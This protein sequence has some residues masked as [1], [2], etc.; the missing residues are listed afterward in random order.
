ML[1]H[2]LIEYAARAEAD[3]ELPPSYYRPKRIQWILQLNADGTEADFVSLREKPLETTAPY[4]YRS[5]TMPPPYL[6]VDTAQY[7]LA[8]PK[9]APGKPVT[10]RAAEEGR[11]RRDAY[12]DLLLA[13]ADAAPDD[14]YA[15][16]V[17]TFVTTG[18]LHRLEAPKEMTAADN[19]ALVAHGNTWLHQLSSV[20]EAWANSVRSRKSGK[21][22]AGLC[23]VCGKE[24]E[25]LSTIPESIK[26]GAIPTAGRGRD[27]QLVSINASAQGR[28][29]ALQLVNTPVCERCGGRAMAAL[30]LLLTSDTNRRR[31]TDSVTVWWTREPADDLF[32]TLDTPTDAVVARLLTSLHEH[33]DPATAERIDP[34]AYYALTLGLNNARAVVLDW[35]DIPVERLRNHLGA[36]FAHHRVYDG[37]NHTY[38]YFPLWRLALAAGR[39]DAK[40]NKYAPGSAPKGLEQELLHA[41]LTR[42]PVPARLLPYLLQ[43]IRADRHVDPPRIALLR[44]ALHPN[45]KD[46]Q[47]TAPADRLDP[48]QLDPGYLCGRV[49]AVLEAIQYAA[50]PDVKATIGDKFF[51]TA[52]TAPA[53]VI[54]TLRLGAAAH[55]KRLRRDNKAAYNALS[56]RLAEAFA[57]FDR[58]EGIPS[59]LTTEQQ[60]KFVLGYEQQRAA[61]F[62]AKAAHKKNKD[63]AAHDAA[64]EAG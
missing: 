30:N 58:H 7:V 46:H 45:R 50:L 28:G 62:A 19:I 24:G 20:R 55:L 26:S 36:W 29:G 14:P 59:M 9:Q 10:E 54:K 16:V 48:A 25:L 56:R 8:L 22:A 1:L 11:R 12:A 51:G 31:A 64:A 18:V 47:V 42:D 34:N 52:M 15:M 4:A 44:L 27:A 5:G 21:N 40:A 3:G 43:R 37:W 32:D 41:A 35:L 38:R 33:P 61:D 57:A 53:A 6:M 60:A 17:R 2:R 13:W 49:F 23:L 63:Q 39:W